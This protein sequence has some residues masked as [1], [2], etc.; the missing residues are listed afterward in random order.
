MQRRKGN[1]SLQRKRSLNDIG[2]LMNLLNEQL[3]PSKYSTIIFE[4]LHS[5]P[6]INKYCSH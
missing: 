2:S 5:F 4:I 6:M 3:Y 1:L